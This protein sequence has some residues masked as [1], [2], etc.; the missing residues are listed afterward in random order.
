MFVLQH[1]QDKAK[2]LEKRGESGSEVKGF[3]YALI[4]KGGSSWCQ[5]TELH[6]GNS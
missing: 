6:S 2:L 3:I 4:Q 5:H 1:N